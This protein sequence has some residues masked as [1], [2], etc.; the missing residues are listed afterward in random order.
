MESNRDL[1]EPLHNATMRI[2]EGHRS[3]EVLE[4]LVSLE[5]MVGVD[6][7]DAFFEL[8]AF[9][10]AIVSRESTVHRR[11]SDSGINNL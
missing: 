6:Q 2:I 1:N 8:G 5:K 7:V 3:P 11:S 9:H 4:D 10:M